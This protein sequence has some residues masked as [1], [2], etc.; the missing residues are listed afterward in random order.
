MVTVTMVHCGVVVITT[1]Q[2]HSGERGLRFVRLIKPADSI[3]EFL[4]LRIS[5]ND[6]SW[7]KG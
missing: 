5:G 7:K 4:M 2:L 6:P 1:A 3:L